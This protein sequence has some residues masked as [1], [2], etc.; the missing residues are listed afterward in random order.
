[1]NA[2]IPVD[3]LKFLKGSKEEL[4]VYLDHET[5]SGSPMERVSGPELTSCATLT[6]HVHVPDRLRVAT[7]LST[8]P[9]N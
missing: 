9:A 3:G 4:N 7:T 1:M 2:V 6:M 5:S 8:F